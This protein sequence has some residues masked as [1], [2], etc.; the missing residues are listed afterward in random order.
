MHKR[1]KKTLEKCPEMKIYFLHEP[2]PPL[3]KCALKYTQFSNCHDG[4]HEGH[5]YLSQAAHS[6]ASAAHTAS[7]PPHC[8]CLP[9][10]KVAE[11]LAKQSKNYQE[12][13]GFERF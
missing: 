10:P 3:S 4:C 8:L 5:W 1:K 13:T 9:P 12:T 2:H 11:G 6:T 7:W